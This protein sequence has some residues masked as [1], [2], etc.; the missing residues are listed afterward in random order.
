MARILL[1]EDDENLG[2]VLKEYLQVHD[3]EVDWVTDGEKGIRKFQD[4]RYD[5]SVIDIMLP[6]VDGFSVA[7]QFRRINENVPFIFLT[8]KSLKVDKLKGF[9]EGCDDYIVKPVDEELL[10]ARINAVIRRTATTSDDE[11]TESVYQVGLYEF[12]YA[13]GKLIRDGHVQWISGKESL[14]LKLLCEQKNKLLDRRKALES[15]WGNPDYFNR[16]T[17]D[18]YITKLRKYLSDDPDIEIANVHGRGFI[19]KDLRTEKTGSESD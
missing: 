19:L 14:L 16:R 13:N 9:N 17:M 11:S 6:K 12:D 5:L 3:Y 8:A 4:N 7:E 15:I 10:I 18:V 1:I 2:Y